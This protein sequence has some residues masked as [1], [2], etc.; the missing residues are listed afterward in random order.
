MMS[1]LFDSTVRVSG[2]REGVWTP[3]D[4]FVRQKTY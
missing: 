4:V 1:L 2:W 3:I